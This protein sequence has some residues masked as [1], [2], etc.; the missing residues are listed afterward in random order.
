MGI[1]NG[2][3]YCLGFWL[4][5]LTNVFSSGILLCLYILFIYVYV[6]A[7]FMF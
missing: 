6:G 4:L 7:H 1:G 3:S 2:L 5:G